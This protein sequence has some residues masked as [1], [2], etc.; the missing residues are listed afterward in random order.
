MVAAGAGVVATGAG[1]VACAVTVGTVSVLVAWCVGVRLG[2]AVRV[3]VVVATAEALSACLAF[4][5]A[6]AIPAMTMI[7]AVRL[8]STV[9][10]LWRCGHDFRAGRPRCP[11]GGPGCPWSRYGGCPGDVPYCGSGVNEGWRG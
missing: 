11:E 4:P 3:G 5:L 7:S 1:V 6:L 2:V 9:S 10:T 8:P